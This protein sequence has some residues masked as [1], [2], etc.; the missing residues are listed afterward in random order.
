MLD[1]FEDNEL[2]FLVRTSWLYYKEGLTQAEVATRLGTTRA[3]VIR[4]LNTAM[5]ESLVEINLRHPR[6]NLL[7]IE[8]EIK[9]AFGLDDA[10]V[11]PTPEDSGI[12][13]TVLARGA[14]LYLRRTLKDGDILGTAWGSTV[15]EVAKSITPMELENASVVMLLGGLTT[16]INNLNPN[17][18]SRLIAEKLN[19]RCFY[20]PVPAIV[21][22]AKLKEFLMNDPLVDAAFE[23]ARLAT[24]ALVGIGDTTGEA[25]LLQSGFINV[26]TLQKL[27]AKGAVGDVVARYF[28]INGQRINHEMD[29]RIVGLDL[30]DLK[31]GHHVVAVAGGGN[32][33]KAILGALRGNYLDVLVTDEQTAKS[34]LELQS[35]SGT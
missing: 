29:N 15:M 32:K 2:E 3:R 16:A 17:D 24:H 31:N 19:A 10:V 22:T 34:I 28:D 25:Q 11:V 9:S 20:L 33:I 14:A 26:P 7:S 12:L 5:N 1:N 8:D 23:V 13:K 30:D 21:S 27:C 35:Q 6:Y 18:T 4:A